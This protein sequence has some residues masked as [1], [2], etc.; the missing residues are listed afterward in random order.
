MRVDLARLAAV[1]GELRRLFAPRR[2]LLRHPGDAGGSAG[3]EALVGARLQG[4]QQ[5][6]Q[7]AMAV[8]RQPQVAGEGP[9]REIALLGVDVDMRP[10]GRGIVRHVARDP[11]HVDIDQHADIRIGQRLG[12]REAAVAGRIVRQVDV[13]RIELDHADAGK[14]RQLVEHGDGGVVAARIGRDQQR[15]LRRE[16]ARDQRLERGG[17]DAARRDR[18]EAVGRIGIDLALAPGRGQRLAREG[19][20]DR[21]L[22]IALHHRV[23]AAQRL[24]GDHAGRQVVLPL[25]VGP[26]DARLVERLLHE[27]HVGVARAQQLVARG[28]GR[29]AGHQHHRHAGAAEIVQRHRRV[30]GAG[31]DMDHHALAAPGGDGVARRH[32]HRRVLVRAK[33]GR[34]HLAAA[35]PEARHRLDQRRVVGAE[36]AEQVVEADLVQPLEEIMRR[37]MARFVAVHGCL[38]RA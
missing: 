18:A 20:V 31:I 35:A 21:P 11:R 36:V 1:G 16:Q 15:T 23:G 5:V 25:G 37:R 26:H 14:T 17:I 2:G 27:M 3:L 28:V 6:G 24:L 29:L 19:H 13:E 34:R 9:D 7:D 10:P 22:G 33:N 30:G 12:R 8:A 4:G 32:V 38:S